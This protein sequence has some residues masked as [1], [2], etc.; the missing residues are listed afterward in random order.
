MVPRRHGTV[1]RS[2]PGPVHGCRRY[3][4]AELHIHTPVRVGGETRHRSDTSSTA[5]RVRGHDTATVGA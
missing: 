3:D 1:L 5:M 4:A 2:G